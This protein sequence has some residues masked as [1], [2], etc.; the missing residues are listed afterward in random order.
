MKVI[1]KLLGRKV[2]KEMVDYIFSAA[3]G[4]GIRSIDLVEAMLRQV[5]DYCY[6]NDLRIPL[7]ISVGH[8]TEGNFRFAFE[9][10]HSLPEISKD[11][12]PS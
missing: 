4:R 1:E 8:I 11:Y 5:F 10:L 7:G 6:G 12:I 3:T 9:L 2:E